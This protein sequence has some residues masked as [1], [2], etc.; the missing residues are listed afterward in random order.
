MRNGRNPGNLLRRCQYRS[1]ASCRL[2]H[3]NQTTRPSRRHIPEQKLRFAYTPCR[4]MPFAALQ[5]NVKVD[6]GDGGQ[7]GQRHAVDVL[8]DHVIQ[9]TPELDGGTQVTAGA[10]VVDA[11]ARHRSRAALNGTQDVAGTH[12][13]RVLGHHVAAALATHALKQVRLNP[14]E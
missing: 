7:V 6:L 1:W 3:E 13:G 5:L 12:L 4:E 11:I 2:E 9:T 10:A 8:F 14:E